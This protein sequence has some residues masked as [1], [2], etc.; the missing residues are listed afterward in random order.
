MEAVGVV[1]YVVDGVD[2]DRLRHGVLGD[3][4]PAAQHVET[5]EPCTSGDSDQ[6]VWHDGRCR[7]GS[8][9]V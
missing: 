3:E 7:G 9:K 4:E 8:N 2:K 1:G 5:H 6:V